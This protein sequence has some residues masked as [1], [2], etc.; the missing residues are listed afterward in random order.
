MVEYDEDE[1]LPHSVSLFKVDI[2]G[3]GGLQRKDESSGFL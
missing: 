2:G 1:Y 3:N